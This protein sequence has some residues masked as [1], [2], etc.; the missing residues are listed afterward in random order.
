MKVVSIDSADK[1]DE[2]SL[3]YSSSK[4]GEFSKKEKKKKFILLLF[5]KKEQLKSQ[6]TLFLQK[7]NIKLKISVLR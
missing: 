1:N 2:L 6:M 7:M 3:N 4:S 5:M